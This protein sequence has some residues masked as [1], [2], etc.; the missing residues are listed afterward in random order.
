M[1]LDAVELVLAV[2]DEFR[3]VIPNGAASK[4][5]LVGDL[6]AFAVQALRARGE[7]ADPAE[8]WG[9]LKRVF[10]AKFAFR[11]EQVVPEAHLVYDL[12]LD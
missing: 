9:R 5:V 4:F 11:E 10:M 6:H 2:E 3:I 1:G 7:P 12:G 8:V